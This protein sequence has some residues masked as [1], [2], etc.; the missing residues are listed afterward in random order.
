MIRPNAVIAEACMSTCGAEAYS[1]L[2]CDC[3]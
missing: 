3:M 2:P 1:L